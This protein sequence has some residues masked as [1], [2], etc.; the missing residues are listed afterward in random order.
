MGMGFISKWGQRFALGL[1]FSVAAAFAATPQVLNLGNGAEPKDL[2]PHIA[3]GVPE[4]H[5]ITN[6]FEG[7]TGKDPKTLAPVPGVAKSWKVSKDGKVYTFT[8]RDDAKWSNGDPVT[9]QDF[10][11]SWT[12]LLQPETAAEYAYEGYYIKNG[13]AFNAGTLKDASK[14]GVKAL[15]ATTLEVTLE[16]PVP[17]FLSLVFHHSLYPVHKATVEKWGRGW[18][19]PEHM[20]TNGAFVLGEWEIN[21]VIKLKKSPTYW[22]HD[23]VILTE[24]NYYP[25]ENLDTEEKM[26]RTKKLDATY[27][28]PLEKLPYWQHDKSGVF[29]SHPWLGV[30]FYR[31]NVTKGP[32]KDKR[33]RQ[34]LNLAIDRGRLVKYVSKGNEDPATAFTP[35]G[36]G[37]FH[38]ES[39]LPTDTSQL[40]KARALLA[41]AGFPDGKN[42]PSLEILYNT[43]E[44]HKKIA[45]AV[46][47]M[48]KQNLGI[49]VT[50]VNQEWK[51]YLDSQ[52]TLNYQLSRAGWIADYNDPNT[53]L[54]MF[55]T[56]GGNNQTG[57]SN[58]KY[59]GFIA[60]ASKELNLTKRLAIFQQAE[61]ILLEEGPVLPIYI[62]KRNYLLS[63]KVAGW[64]NNIEDVHPLKYVSIQAPEVAS[65]KH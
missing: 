4:F 50:L 25:T 13:K 59:D 64:F 28:V 46:Q 31:L 54:D 51:V 27:E 19:R 44:G 18:T 23:R 42:F 41:E 3:T 24:A 48:L 62:Y 36:C 15:N 39:K 43:H 33:V 57:W 32:L 61:N 12:R 52:K 29:Q 65:A 45:E 35:P 56:D 2:D 11:Y 22:D 20:V 34:A 40:A 9:A 8:L 53:F 26:F 6:L 49:P 1:C 17:F 16:N 47:E 38:P 14:L 55:V 21:K 30:Y 10:V 60:A 7:L 63:T 5:I 37:N 58:K